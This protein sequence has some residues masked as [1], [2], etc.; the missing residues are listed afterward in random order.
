MKRNKL[1]QFVHRPRERIIFDSTDHI[2]SFML[3]V[4]RPTKN[5]YYFELKYLHYFSNNLYTLIVDY[6]LLSRDLSMLLYYKSDPVASLRKGH[7]K[8]LLHRKRNHQQIEEATN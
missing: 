7:M 3:I 1:L 4:S 2:Y 8:N 6:T 5:L